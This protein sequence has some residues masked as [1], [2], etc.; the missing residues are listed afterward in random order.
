VSN[1]NLFRIDLIMGDDDGD[2]CARLS[3]AGSE[4]GEAVAS[5]LT[6]MSPHVCQGRQVAVAR[7]GIFCESCRCYH[8]IRAKHAP[9]EGHGEIPVENRPN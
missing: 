3:V 6:V 7:I 8:D 2:E 4:L 1:P 5:T 9:G